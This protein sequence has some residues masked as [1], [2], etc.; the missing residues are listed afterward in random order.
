MI[1]QRLKDKEKA[2]V[3]EPERPKSTVPKSVKVNPVDF[4]KLRDFNNKYCL[5]VHAINDITEKSGQSPT[6]IRFL[7][8]VLVG[9]KAARG[10]SA[11]QITQALSPTNSRDAVTERIN[12]VDSALNEWA[13]LSTAG[14][15]D[16]PLDR[17]EEGR[18]CRFQSAIFVPMNDLTFK[19]EFYWLITNRMGVIW[20]ETS[21]KDFSHVQKWVSKMSKGLFT[22]NFPKQCNSSLVL[23]TAL[24]F[25]G[26]WAQPLELCGSS[27]GSFEVSP[28]TR[29][30]IPM[31]SI[32][33]EVIYYKDT[34]KGFHLVGIPFKDT[35]FA[36]VF[37]LPL[38]PH[39][40]AEVEH[41]FTEGLDYGLFNSSRVQLCS[42]H[43]TMPMFRVQT[44]VDLC[45]ALPFLGMNNPFDSDQ[46]DFSGISDVENLRIDSGKESAFLQVSRSGVRLF[47]VGTLS[48][49]TG[50]HQ[51]KH[52]D[53]FEVPILGP[54]GDGDA[55]EVHSF[56]VNQPFSVIIINRKSD[57]VL[58]QVR[59]KVPEPPSNSKLPAIN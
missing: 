58:Y 1:P 37:L 14:L 4:L 35:R 30:D 9:S 10:T 17:L 50:R 59:V 13:L 32:V 41:G 3:P 25:K 19:A 49:G 8:T 45:K 5:G 22:H 40:F 39:K 36:I 28:N 21:R 51:F 42:M 57:C 2:A 38:V 56:T 20:T 11:D 7:L 34:K 26:E 53:L 31:L 27:K 54:P 46:A 29:I 52:P 43:V 16:I 24:Q 23:A 44:E 47:S 55:K 12:L 33:A 15:R 6:T 48:L 18:L